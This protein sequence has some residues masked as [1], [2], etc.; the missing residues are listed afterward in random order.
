VL[1]LVRLSEPPTQPELLL[2]AALHLLRSPHVTMPHPIM[3]V[4]EWLARHAPT[5]A[6]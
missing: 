5:Y 2:L 1:S 4:D 6:P 3:S